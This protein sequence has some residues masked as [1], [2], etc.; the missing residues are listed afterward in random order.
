[1]RIRVLF[2][3]LAAVQIF[4]QSTSS[5]ENF[6][7]LI[8]SVKAVE[9]ID[10]AI[11]LLKENMPQL[12]ITSEKKQALRLLGE[13][14]ELKGN[15]QDAQ[16]AY[17]QAF[18]LEESDY[19]MLYRSALMLHYMGEYSSSELKLLSVIRNSGNREIMENS[20]LLLARSF[21]ARGDTE[22][23]NEVKNQISNSR[24]PQTL[25]F[26]DGQ[27]QDFPQSPEYLLKKGEIPFLPDPLVSLGM[28]GNREDRIQTSEKMNSPPVKETG[29]QVFLI[30]TG[31]FLDKENA[32]YLS[33]DLK[34]LGFNS[35]VEA[36]QI[37]GKIYNKV[38]VTAE[39]VEDAKKLILKLKDKGFE[40][41]P[42]Y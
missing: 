27:L 39:S 7:T 9:S 13:Y 19:S 31:S 30:Q 24:N 23:Y 12:K 2:F 35:H 28:L 40:G 16:K 21:A 34:A 8:T 6:D 41:Y 4:A 17:N 22:G 37:N 25:F 29:E 14:E 18:E 10:K 3:L 5:E 36:Q 38:F 32:E 26:L 33:K 15:Y 11:S 42:I 20:Y 1:M